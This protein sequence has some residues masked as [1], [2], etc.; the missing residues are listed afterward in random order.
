MI[1]KAPRLVLALLAALGA[2]PAPAAAASRTLV[3]P[4]QPVGVSHATAAAS[5][6]LLAG[7]L[8]DMG[9]EVVASDSAGACS[10]RACAIARARERDAVRVVFGSL[11]WV[12]GQIVA[13]VEM[14]DVEGSGPHFRDQRKANFEADLD[15]L[16]RR[17][18]EAIAS[19]RHQVD[20]QSVHSITDFDAHAPVR[21][22]SLERFG[23]R[24]GFLL[25][26]SN[27]YG[28]SN[29]LAGLRA[30]H[31]HEVGDFQVEVTPLLGLLWNDAVL[32]WTLIDVSV[33]HLFGG[34]DLG[35]YLGA[36]VGIHEVT[37]DGSR[38]DRRTFTEF[39]LSTSSPAGL[40]KVTAPSI[41]LVAGVIALR[42][43]D[44]TLL[45]DV[46]YHHML[47]RFREIGGKGANGVLLT[48][49]ASW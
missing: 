38:I 27:S 23:V 20:R 25:P 4:L 41:D 44:F 1:R 9:L 46:R 5:H 49:G 47:A 26:T 48:F 6:E 12:S 37:I 30:V 31:R 32:D 45:A 36:G 29:R 7:Y 40:Q 35:S 39:P 18:A 16:M 10:E 19:G 15:G 13:R 21:R 14:V 3:L 28:S 8:T 11:T 42:T 34:R 2:A 22:A 43:A 24:A 17:F 33:A